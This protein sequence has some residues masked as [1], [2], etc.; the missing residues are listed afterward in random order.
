MSNLEMQPYSTQLG[1]F[2]Q[3]FA[4]RQESLVVEENALSPSGGD[5]VIKN[6]DGDSLF[7]VTGHKS[8]FSS[9]RTHVSDMKRNLLFA[10]GKKKFGSG[11]YAEG[12]DGKSILDIKDDSSETTCRFKSH[13]G[14]QE[15]LV[16]RATHPHARAEILDQTTGQLVAIVNRSSLVGLVPTPIGRRTYTVM[17]A[18]GVD[19]ALIVA[20]C[21]CRRHAFQKFQNSLE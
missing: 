18:P 16:N 19:M 14:R 4:R 6:S 12:A 5:F 15:A 17:V 13:L 10:I 8:R 20:V 21:L 7:Q 2:P 11:F 9:H 1:L 3:F